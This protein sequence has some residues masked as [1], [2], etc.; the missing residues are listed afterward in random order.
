MAPAPY[1]V[2]WSAAVLL[3]FPLVVAALLRWRRQDLATGRALV[4]L[5]VILLLPG[6]GA[7]VH[8]AVTPSR[9]PRDSGQADA[10]G[11]VG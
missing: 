2:L 1:D 11:P 4:W 6:L 10:T 5:L 7:A 3:V 8:L 9:A